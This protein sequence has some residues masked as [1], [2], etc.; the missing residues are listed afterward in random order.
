MKTL[1]LIFAFLLF[2]TL[3]GCGG[4]GGGAT[5]GE[6]PQLTVYEK[7]ITSFD[8]SSH[9]LTAPRL[10]TVSSAGLLTVAEQAS[11]VTFNTTNGSVA[12]TYAVSN[13]FGVAVKPGTNDVY[14]TGGANSNQGVFVNGNQVP[15]PS[16]NA[17]LYGIAFATSQDWYVADVAASLLIY[18]NNSRGNPT[19]VP[20]PTGLPSALVSNNGLI[21]VSLA[22]AHASILSFNPAN[23]SDPIN[24][25]FTTL[26]SWGTFDFPN[27]LAV[28][29]DYAYIANAGDAHGDNGYI[30]RVKIS[31]GTKEVFASNS[32][33]I[34]R[35]TGMGFCGPA[36]LAIY[37][38]YLYVSNGT[39][40]SGI[41]QNQ[42]LKINLQ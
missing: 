29:G 6:N 3:L 27:G 12:S 8:T 20:V 17:N 14:Y 40:T 11:I 9:P 28:D 15:I 4:G 2:A 38:K 10:M 39:C 42:I 36:G 7:T 41:N 33:G 25:G 30:S 24:H 32:V 21:Y 37:N 19:S 5:G 31:N 18:Q 26:L 23:A 34:W 16:T 22:G 1:K 13:P 35:T